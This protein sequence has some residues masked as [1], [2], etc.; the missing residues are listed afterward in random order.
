MK[1]LILST[2]LALTSMTLQAK[3]LT[4]QQP[5]QVASIKCQ[6]FK[7]SPERAKY[8]GGRKVKNLIPFYDAHHCRYVVNWQK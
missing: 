7:M 5:L 1:T 4:P 2:V 3:H 8:P 6:P